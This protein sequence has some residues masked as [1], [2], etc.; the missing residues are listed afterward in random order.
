MSLVENLLDAPGTFS[1]DCVDWKALKIFVRNNLHCSE[2]ASTHN[3][4]P[5]LSS[6][7]ACN[8]IY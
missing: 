5:R 1:D 4:S 3:L 8:Q 2:S 6:I 7:K